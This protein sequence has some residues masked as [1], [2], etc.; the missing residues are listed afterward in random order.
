M[1][2]L[3]NPIL[4]LIMNYQRSVTFQTTMNDN[5]A[6][7][8]DPGVRDDPPLPWLKK[9]RTVSPSSTQSTSTAAPRTPPSEQNRDPSLP[10]T[11]APQSQKQMALIQTIR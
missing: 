4:Y 6:G 5:E 11:P 9:A 10:P 1:N 3:K 7:S 2:W 8:W